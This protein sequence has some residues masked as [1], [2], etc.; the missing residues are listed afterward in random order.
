MTIRKR[1][2]YIYMILLLLI[3]GLTGCTKKEINRQVAESLGTLGMYEN[4]EPVETPKMKADKQMKESKDAIELEVTTHLENAENLAVHYDYYGALEELAQINVDYQDDKRVVDKKINYTKLAD[5][6]MYHAGTIPHFS[7]GNLAVDKKRAYNNPEMGYELNMWTLTA[8]EFK[9]ILKQLYENN[10][11]LMNIQDIVSEHEDPKNPKSVLLNWEGVLVPEGKKPIV[12]S[13][14]GA[15]YEKDYYEYG[16]SHRMVIDSDGK[17]KNEYIDENGRTLTGAYDV[18]PILDEFVEENPGFSLGGAKGILAITGYKGAF[19]YND[20]TDGAMIQRIADTLKAEG[21]TIAC[22]GYRGV[23]MESDL[24][25]DEFVEDLQNWKHRIGKYVGDTGMLLYPH[26][27]EVP[28]YA[29]K[30]MWALEHGFHYFFSQ[31]ATADTLT[32][33]DDCLM[34]SR[35]LLNGYDLYNY[36]DDMS[37]YFKYKKVLDKERPPFEE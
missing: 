3:L 33:Y 22:Q 6:L 34:Q 30:H 31:W 16:F 26:G 27:E 4:D 20:Q 13:F 12:L 11:V 19:G 32:V 25:A 18:V 35:R 37:Q 23:S 2:I 7:V 5:S 17:V 21:W 29:F 28:L 10:Y 1:I 14:T 15:G 9:E 24:D 8:E 36:G